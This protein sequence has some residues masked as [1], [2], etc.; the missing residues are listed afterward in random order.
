M[1]DFLVYRRPSGGLIELGHEATSTII[2]YAQ[3]APRAPEAGGILLGRWLV[4]SQDIVVDEVTTP[5]RSDSRRRL[6][7]FRSRSSHQQRASAA[8]RESGGTCH[9]LGEWHTHPQH[10]PTPSGVD[11]QDWLRHLSEDTF[12]RPTLFFVIVG[13]H[14]INIWEGQRGNGALQPLQE[15]SPRGDSRSLLQRHC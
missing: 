12:V 8:W 7:F 3:H 5:T 11:I 14:S 15:I 13:T 10:T 1:S 6:W 2:R 9:Y 4:D